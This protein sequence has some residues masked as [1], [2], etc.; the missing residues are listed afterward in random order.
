MNSEANRLAQPA[1]LAHVDVL[2]PTE[3]VDAALGEAGLPTTDLHRQAAALVSMGVATALVEDDEAEFAEWLSNA[4]VRPRNPFVEDILGDMGRY[5][6]HLLAALR[7]ETQ[8][9]IEGGLV[10]RLQRLGNLLGVPPG[11]VAEL[12]LAE[13]G[14]ASYNLASVQPGLDRRSWQDQGAPRRLFPFEG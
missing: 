12:L 3:M 10:N 2:F 4:M 14:L 13:A 9:Q 5:L 6:E 8:G 1:G 7:G 11:R